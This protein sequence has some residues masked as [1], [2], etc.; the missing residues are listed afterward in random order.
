MSELEAFLQAHP[1]FTLRRFRELAGGR[2]T[3]ASTQAR[4]KYHLGRG[5]L[6]LVEKGVYAVVPPGV[7]AKRFVPDRFLVAAAIRDDAVVAYHSALELL[8]YAHSV[9]RGALYFTARRRKDLRLVDARVRAVLHPAPLRSRQE[10]GY[11]VETRE[12]LGVKL[13][14]TGPERTLV[15]CLATPRYAGGLEEVFQSAGGIPALDLDRLAGYLDRLG[16]RRLYAIVGFYLEGEA[17]RLFV[18]PEFLERLARKRPRSRIYLE[19]RQRGGRLQ[20]RWN[21]I[22]PDRWARERP[23]VEV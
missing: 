10:E 7:D 20:A 18:P 3:P 4:I 11:G 13:R 6:K 16:Q 21:L 2:A 17:S 19:P 8:G 23:A 14:V 22:V 1:V 15:D 9:Y 5:R 12:R